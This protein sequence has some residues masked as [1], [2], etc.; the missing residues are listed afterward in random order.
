MA[1]FVLSSGGTDVDLADL[2][3]QVLAESP[4]SRSNYMKLY[5]IAVMAGHLQRWFRVTEPLT[6]PFRR[7][8]VAM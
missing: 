7:F 4:T 3:Q 5:E 6:Q 1:A 8:K 2:L